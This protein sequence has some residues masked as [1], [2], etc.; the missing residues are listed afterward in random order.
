VAEGAQ[1]LKS[2][3]LV[4]NGPNLNLLGRREPEV[5]GRVTLEEIESRLRSRAA[6]L[7]IDLDSR[8]SNHEG[9]LIDW[10]QEALEGWDVLI[11]NPGGLTHTS[12]GLRDAVAALSI[13][14]LEV[15]LTNIY[16]REGFRRRSLVSP[17]ASAVLSGL[18]A[19]VYE[20]ALE[21]AADLLERG[22]RP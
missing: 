4:L 5:Y 1:R 20:L 8:Q 2:R 9:V 16:A 18:G 21:G 13:P 11:L 10:V 12:V 14:V 22:E 15:H 7:G 19:R 6:E 3:V 17:V